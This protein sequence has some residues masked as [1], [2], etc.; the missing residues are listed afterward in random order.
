MVSW[1]LIAPHGWMGFV[2]RCRPFYPTQFHQSAHPVSVLI[3]YPSEILTLARYWFC[4]HRLW[5]DRGRPK[6][7]KIIANSSVKQVK[8]QRTGYDITQHNTSEKDQKYKNKNTLKPKP[9]INLKWNRTQTTHSKDFRKAARR[10]T[11]TYIRTHDICRA[12]EATRRREGDTGKRVGAWWSFN[13][14]FQ[15][16][17][18]SANCSDCRVRARSAGTYR[19]R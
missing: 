9:K 8:C 3:P 15:K 6:H 1:F 14:Y 2:F 18:E 13:Y 12:D 7:E 19:Y 16:L 11:F 5:E 17:K 4:G 10:E